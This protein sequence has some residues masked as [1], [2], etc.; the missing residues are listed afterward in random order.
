MRSDPI[1]KSVEDGVNVAIYDYDIVDLRT[2]VRHHY[3]DQ[4]ICRMFS[5]DDIA[6]HSHGVFQVVN[7]WE[8]FADQTNN[9]QLC[10]LRALT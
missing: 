7:S 1:E 8:G 5:V 6:S 9:R 3:V 2:G 10:L 4:E